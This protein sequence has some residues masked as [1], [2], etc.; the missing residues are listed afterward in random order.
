MSMESLNGPNGS[1]YPALKPIVRSQSDGSE[2]VV[3]QGAGE[4][5]FGWRLTALHTEI[6]M[7]V[8]DKDNPASVGVSDRYLIK[9][10]KAGTRI[11]VVGLAIA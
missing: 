5:T 2:A 7:F 11:A 8:L 4:T 1:G 9:Y 3:E 6:E 10:F